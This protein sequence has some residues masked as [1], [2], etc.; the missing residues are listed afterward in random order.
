[1]QQVLALNLI[2]KMAAGKT[3]RSVLVRHVIYTFSKSEFTG[4][5]TILSGLFVCSAVCVIISHRCHTIAGLLFGIIE[6][7]LARGI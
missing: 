7:G 2:G 6:E 1:M 4:N 3:M 5:T